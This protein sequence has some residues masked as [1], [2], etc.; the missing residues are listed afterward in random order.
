[1]NTRSWIVIV[2]IALMLMVSVAMKLMAPADPSAE[3]NAQLQKNQSHVPA[4]KID[5]SD[6]NYGMYTLYD[7]AQ[8]DGPITS[9]TLKLD[10]RI[11]V[12][13][14]HLGSIRDGEL[15]KIDNIPSIDMASYSLAMIFDS[16]DV[17]ENL[18]IRNSINRI[19]ITNTSTNPSYIFKKRSTD[20]K[21]CEIT[22]Y[23]YS[24]KKLLKRSPKNIYSG[25]SSADMEK[26]Y[27]GDFKTTNDIISCFPPM[28]G[29]RACQH[30]F[31]FNSFN[32]SASYDYSDLQ[33]WKTIKEEVIDLLARSSQP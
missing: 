6:P 15:N 8:I 23:E 24:L 16:D 30:R 13:I 33:D 2:S 19:S 14:S 18:N 32:V 9:I 28:I 5:L 1:M 10:K 4:P 17:K 29:G 20:E 22:Q 12:S 25:C 27:S 11:T 26:Y 7:R 31:N 3:S 21:H